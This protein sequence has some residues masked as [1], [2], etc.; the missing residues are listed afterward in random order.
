MIR[1][2]IQ[3]ICDNDIVAREVLTSD[4]QV[5][6]GE[7][8]TLKRSYISRL[9]ELGVTEVFVKE[10]IAEIVEIGILKDDIKKTVSETVK[11]VLERHTY[12][13]NEELKKLSETTDSIV[14][15]I[16]E[17]EQAVEKIF[18][19][20]E[21]NADIYEHSIQVCATSILTALKL[22][23]DKDKIQEIGIGCLLHEIGLRY[24]SIE[25]ENQNIK[26]LKALDQIEYRKH[27]A[28]G[29]SALLTEDW[30][31]PLSKNIILHHH[32]KLDGSGFPLRAKKIPFEC[33]IVI[34][35]DTFDEL[36]C[37][38]GYQKIKVHEAI[39]YLKNFTGIWFDKKIVDT[40]LS[41]TAVYPVG[42]KVLTN[43][44]ETAI[45]IGQNKDFQNRPILQV[46][47]DK[48]GREVTEKVIKDLV[49]INN[50]FIEKT[51]D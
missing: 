45:V 18:D 9:E 7:G 16:L 26:S 28:Y 14:T 1:K 43:E 32:E 6:L 5:I 35:C 47:A 44:G 36:I 31:S 19:I 4:L 17:E 37:G 13:Q 3:D 38:I 24:M 27:P 39:E 51:M 33:Q 8:T 10:P 20:K 41:F 2:A 21:R 34:V 40:F 12:R 22:G 42:T 15:T 50:I 30:I 29:Y 48:E 46:I 23:V 49:K 11:S 25:Y